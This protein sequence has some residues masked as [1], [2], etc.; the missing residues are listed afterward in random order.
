MT[1][2]CSECRKEKPFEDFHKCLSFKRGY[3]YSCIEC[4][5]N[6]VDEHRD[7]VYGYTHKNMLKNI[8]KVKAYQKEYHKNYYLKRKQA[9][10]D[11]NT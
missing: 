10:L 2:F 6:Y 9:K 11:G 1:L 3:Q 5:K 4:R 8:E 7:T